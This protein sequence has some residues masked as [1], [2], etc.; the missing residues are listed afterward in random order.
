VL[1]IGIYVEDRH[2]FD[3]APD[4]DP[5]SQFDADPDPYPDPTLDFLVHRQR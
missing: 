2:V 4:P 5:T 3:A 1:F